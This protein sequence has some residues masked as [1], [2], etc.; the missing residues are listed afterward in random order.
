MDKLGLVL[1]NIVFFLFP[2]PFLLSFA[3]GQGDDWTAYM[4]YAAVAVL[5]LLVAATTWTA[6][7]RKRE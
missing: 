1:R 3:V 7:G 2:V 4:A 6:F 5:A